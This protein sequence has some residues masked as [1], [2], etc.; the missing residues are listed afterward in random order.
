[1]HQS[2]TDDDDETQNESIYFFWKDP[3]FVPVPVVED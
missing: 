1:M 3:R 2:H